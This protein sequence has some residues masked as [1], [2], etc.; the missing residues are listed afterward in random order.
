[1]RLQDVEQLWL[2]PPKFLLLPDSDSPKPKLQDQ[3]VTQPVFTTTDKERTT[4]LKADSAILHT[5]AIVNRKK[6]S[7]NAK[8]N[9]PLI[10][11]DFPF[12]FVYSAQLLVLYSSKTFKNRRPGDGYNSTLRAVITCY[13]P[14]YYSKVNYKQTIYNKD[15]LL[16]YSPFMDDNLILA[17]GPLRHSPMPDATK[18]PIILHAKE[19][20]I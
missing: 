15:A 2:Q 19:P 8:G 13:F 3:A 6:F 18:Y 12:D 10:F 11:R 5:N 9:Q 14:W 7:T 16:P 17:R 4:T 20:S 1:M